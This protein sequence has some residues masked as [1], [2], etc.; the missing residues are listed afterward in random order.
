[1][2]AAR[3]AH[4]ASSMVVTQGW[5]EC[6]AGLAVCTMGVAARGE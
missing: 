4:H 2:A 5:G 1:L 6:D 3:A